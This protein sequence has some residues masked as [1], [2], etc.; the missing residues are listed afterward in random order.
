[1]NARKEIRDAIL[2]RRMKH[3]LMIAK[4]PFTGKGCPAWRARKNYWALQ[5][6]HE[7]LAAAHDLSATSVF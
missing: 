4:Y 6:K 5:R 2:L 3:W 1:M 7:A